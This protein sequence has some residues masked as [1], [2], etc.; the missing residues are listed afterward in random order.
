[1]IGG[2]P[3]GCELAQTFARLGSTVHLLEAAPQVLI[4]EDPEAAAIVRTALERDGVTVHTEAAIERVERAGNGKSVALG[5]GE[6]LEVDEILV[7]A[8]RRPNV[9]GLGLEAAGVSFDPRRGV[10]VDDTLRT[11]HP[12]VYAVGDCAMRW[13]FTHA[14]DAAAKIVVQNALFCGRKKLSALVMPWCTYTDPEVAHIGL[15]EH[16]AAERGVETDVHGVPMKDN[17]RA[18][19]DGETEGFVKILT[20]RGRDEIVGATVVASHAGDLIATLGVAMAGKVG[21]ATI[22]GAIFPYP[23]QA[24]ALKGAANQYMRSRLTP[25]IKRVFERVLA[26]RR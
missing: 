11:T 19:C 24:E 16:E 25:R 7:A 20:R 17:D 26:W 15:Y 21:L 1:M 3:I 2:G 9:E 6:R 12:N 10:E 18:R 8:G 5:A 22:A 13:K 23:T 14:A 4:R